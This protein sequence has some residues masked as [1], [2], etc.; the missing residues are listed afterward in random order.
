M[1]DSSCCPRAP[2]GLPLTTHSSRWV[3]E[4]RAASG[5]GGRENRPCCVLQNPVQ[6][7]FGV[8]AQISDLGSLGHFFPSRPVSWSFTFVRRPCRCGAA[9]R[10]GGRRGPQ[11][12]PP[13]L[14]LWHPSEKP[15]PLCPSFLR[16]AAVPTPLQGP[17]QNTSSASCVVPQGL[18]KTLP[19]R[20]PQDPSRTTTPHLVRI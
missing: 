16:T 19:E 14:P 20:D 5:V 7:F 9:G 8:F 1:S 11:P 10:G 17:V 13:E 18:S 12:G 2:R 15:A 3:R 4:S 6:L